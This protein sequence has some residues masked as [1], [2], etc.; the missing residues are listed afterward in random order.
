[1]FVIDLRN[2][3]V[4]K[5]CFSV[6]NNNDVDTVYIYSHFTQYKDYLCYLK[7]ISE[8][9]TYVDEFL[10]D[11]EK[12]IIEDNAL[13]VEWTLGAISTHCK[14]I[15][16]QLEFRENQE[17][18]SK[19]AQSSIVDIVLGDTLD[20][21]EKIAVLY[22]DILKSLQNQIDDLNDGSVASFDMSYVND[23]LTINLKNAEGESV[24]SLQANIP[25][26]TKVDKVEGMGLSHNDFT[27][28]LLTKLNGI[29]QGAQ[30][31]VIE[32]VQVDGADL[33]IDANK[34]VNITN[35]VTKT[36]GANK[37]Y[38]TDNAGAQTTFDIDN[39]TGYSGSVARRDSN[40]Q[41]HVPLTPTANSHAVS[42]K[43]LDDRIAN[44]QRDSYKP[45]DITTYPT[46]NDFLA[47]TGEEGFLYLYPIDTTEAP[48]FESGFYRYIWENNAWV[49]LGTTQIDLS[50]YYTKL[51]ANSIFATKEE[52]RKVIS[53]TY[54]QLKT[55]RDNSEL[56]AGMYYRIIDYQCTTD[57]I[58][59]QSANHTFDVIVVADDESH[60]NE[61][62]R[63]VKHAGDTYFANSKLEA[64][65]IKYC[66]DNDIQRFNWAR[67]DAI[68]VIFEESS[69]FVY[70]RCPQLDNENGFAWVFYNNS[71]DIEG[72]DYVDNWNAL[73]YEDLIYTST[74]QPAIGD[75]LDMSGE[76]VRVVAIRN[77]DG[78]GIVYYM[79]DE[80][81]NECHY[82]FKNILFKRNIVD[83]EYSSSNEGTDMYFYTFSFLKEN[84]TILDTS[85]FGN[86]GTLLNDEMQISGVFNNKIKEYYAYDYTPNPTSPTLWLNDSVF[87][88]SYTYEDETYYGCR[89]NTIEDDGYFNTFGSDCH[90]NIIKKSC[91]G[92][93]FYSSCCYNTLESECFNNT[94]GS[95]CSYNL[96]GCSC[97]NNT[98]GEGCMSNIL[99]NACNSNTFGNDCG[100]NVF[101]PSCYTNN[102][103]AFCSGNVFGRGCGNNFLAESTYNSK[104]GDGVIRVKILSNHS[105][106]IIIGNDCQCVELSLA[107]GLGT[108]TMKHVRVH[109]GIAGTIQ[110]PKR[111]EVARNIDYET[112]F[113]LA[114]SI[115]IEV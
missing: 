54:A 53:V 36:N 107:S 52:A 34:K 2:K 97:S 8:D 75:I 87:L 99:G 29:A 41:L 35:K 114:N 113:V 13:R 25:T 70:V 68:Q 103:S 89:Y 63:A 96:L 39:G 38:G 65:K 79:C 77:N 92:N 85:I 20:V 64:W 105:E 6:M 24:A 48:T 59:T 81:G 7:V 112:S 27:D 11:S 3:L 9:E 5:Y 22:P 84:E 19:V 58:N 101:N 82:D 44:I 69:L 50:N 98:F 60:L 94:F 17:D 51:E 66:I 28:A 4:G 111:L 42:K 49:D 91:N 46:L 55:L 40:G 93:T 108:S 15:S 71:D 90:G 86:D 47:S 57:Q 32:G 67:R 18:N 83:G 106:D 10:I 115:K 102:L 26:S 45:V 33:P 72:F 12:V 30:V 23:V 56:I 110:S 61:N 73:D 100:S 76:E 74:T 109:A 37:V 104:Y 80:Y 1:M 14:K 16:I 78:K 88:S 95:G 62:A 31:N 21:S 43:Y